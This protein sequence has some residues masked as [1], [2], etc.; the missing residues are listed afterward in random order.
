MHQRFCGSKP[1]ET[2]RP[3]ANFEITSIEEDVLSILDGILRTVCENSTPGP[4]GWRLANIFKKSM[5]NK[6]IPSTST[7]R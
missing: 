1:L 6:A 7:P 4:G 2:E 5:K 3:V